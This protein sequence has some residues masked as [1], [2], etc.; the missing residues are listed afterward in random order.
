MVPRPQL[1]A[2]TFALILLI[3]LTSAPAWGVEP[4]QQCLECHRVHYSAHGKCTLCHRG[5][6]ASGRVNIAHYGLIAGRFARF[7][8]KDDVV[9]REGQHLLEQF[10]CRR[11]HVT[12]GRGNRLAANLDG[13]R[14]ERKPG[15]IAA[16]IRNPA[17]GMPDF[18][19]SEQQTV[20]LVNAIL[21]GGEG[22]KTIPG[23]QPKAIHFDADDGR[24]KDVFSR[25]CGACHRTLTVKRGALGQGTIAPNLS[26]VLSR[27]YPKT[28]RNGREWNRKGLEE[29]LRN[30]RLVRS[31]ARMQPV[32]LTAAERDELLELFRTDQD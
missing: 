27:W 4:R 10:A 5:N 14:L 21:A 15:D 7:A 22:Q 29:W 20:A 2:H 9:V 26:G 13:L 24:Q 12:G 6:P 23:G 16:A 18:R 28:F 8:L 19:V 30:P 1:V 3:A 25:K 17:L 11:C 32:K 31:Q